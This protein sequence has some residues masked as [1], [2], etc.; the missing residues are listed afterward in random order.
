MYL[1]RIDKRNLITFLIPFCL[2]MFLLLVFSPG[3]ISYDGN[4]QWE[5]IVSGNINNAH[6]FFTTYFMLLLSKIWNSPTV[7]LA[8][9]VFIFSYF[10]MNIAR[11]IRENNKKSFKKI[12]IY[13]IVISFIL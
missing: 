7:V 5:Q 11:I 8:F 6:P 2:F 3:I 9:Q 1:K 13:T 10:W 12:L 4:N